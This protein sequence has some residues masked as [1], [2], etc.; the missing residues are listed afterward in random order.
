MS[1]TIYR[2]KEIA[3][4]IEQAFEQYNISD[5]GEK[6]EISRDI[7]SQLDATAPISTVLKHP[8]ASSATYRTNV[9]NSLIDIIAQLLNTKD[10]FNR[11][12]RLENKSRQIVQTAANNI[13]LLESKLLNINSQIRETFEEGLDS[14]EAINCIVKDGKLRLDNDE[15]KEPIENISYTILPTDSTFNNTVTSVAGKA[16]Y[17]LKTGVGSDTL[18]IKTK[19][20]ILPS[21]Y[22]GQSLVK[23]IAVKLTVT[24]AKILLN[25][26]TTKLGS[27]GRIHTI[28]GYNEITGLWERFDATDSTNS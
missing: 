5:P 27:I 23:G 19:S 11:L 4:L 8:S 20:P 7:I 18:H 1:T 13:L 22:I 15:N 21:L 6:A 12:D 17:L 14:G 16:E 28:E 25:E 2:Q 10:L 24:T 3:K 26:V 9:R